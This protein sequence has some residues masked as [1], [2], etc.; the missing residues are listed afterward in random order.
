M[1]ISIVI[2]LSHVEFGILFKK[3]EIMDN[4]LNCSKALTRCHQD[5]GLEVSPGH[6]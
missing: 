5:Y 2:S 6:E 4:R 1:T 3:N